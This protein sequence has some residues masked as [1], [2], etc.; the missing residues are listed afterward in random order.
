MT[1]VSTIRRQLGRHRAAN[2]VLRPLAWSALLAAA[3][4]AFFQPLPASAAPV[5]APIGVPDSGSRPAPSGP[6]TMPGGA[7][8]NTAT[9]GTTSL[10]A[11]TSELFAKVEAKRTQ[12]ALLAE[13]LLRLRQDE[14]IAKQ[15]AA[16]ALAQL[17]AAEATLAAAQQ[18]VNEAAGQALRDAAG[19]PTGQ[20][21]SGLNGLDRLNRIQRGQSPGQ[22]AAT[23][24]FTLAEAGEAAARADHTNAD[25]KAKALGAD[26]AKL[27]G[28][29]QRTQGEL[30]AL[31]QQNAAQLAADEAAALAREQALGTQ[32]VGGDASGLGADPKAQA[33]VAYA[34][35]QVGDPYLWAAEGP[36]KFD[37]SGL[38]L[39]SYLSAGYRGLPRVAVDQYAATRLRSVQLSALVPG[40]LLFFSSS[41]SWTDIHHVAMYV[42]GGKMVEAPRAG[43]NVR[44]TTVRWSRIFAATR[45][46]QRGRGEADRL[47]QADAG[48]DV[49][50]A[51]SEAVR[52]G[53][54]HAEHLDVAVARPV[55]FRIAQ[56]QR[57]DIA[58][59]QRIQLRRGE[60]VRVGLG[61]G[62][63]PVVRVGL[64]TGRFQ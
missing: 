52:F 57:V 31:E 59:T 4:G 19:V 35:A 17:T 34:I 38:V 48:A 27:D 22:E 46:S 18:Q 23:R 29:Y 10:P 50:Q 55:G 32:Y 36:D 2:P 24:A 1:T 28:D 7:A 3:M 42:G 47:G 15:Q 21:D 30:T 37:C 61:F 51:G 14:T 39:A 8:T 56:S 5:A 43:V 6:L 49:P 26:V 58:V 54:P 60:S 62:R 63:R 40:D 16:T 64:R 53:R 20:F 44:V 25:A 33:A 9:T 12:V 13:R 11:G 41:S 45:V